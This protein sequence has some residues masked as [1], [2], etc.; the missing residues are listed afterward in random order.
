MILCPAGYLVRCVLLLSG[1]AVSHCPKVPYIGWTSGGS[2]NRRRSAR[3]HSV[4]ADLPGDFTA[5]AERSPSDY[6]GCTAPG[7]AWRRRAHRGGGVI[8]PPR[9]DSARRFWVTVADPD[10]KRRLPSPLGR[11]MYWAPC[12]TSRAVMPPRSNAWGARNSYRPASRHCDPEEPRDLRCV[13]RA[14]LSAGHR[15]AQGTA[16]RYSV[17]YRPDEFEE[18]TPR[19]PAA[20]SM[21][22]MIGPSREAPLAGSLDLVRAGQSMGG[23]RIR[24]QRQ[25]AQADAARISRRTFALF[26]GHRRSHLQMGLQTRWRRRGQAVGEPERNPPGRRRRRKPAPSPGGI[27]VLAGNTCATAAS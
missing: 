17:A 22:P 21:T 25:L 9:M 10:P 24:P 7:S 4:P 19:S 8:L 23:C 13:R 12:R 16:I 14:I 20:T 1:G 18:V 2:R 15:T 6:T 11:P 5:L 27:G 3:L 26:G